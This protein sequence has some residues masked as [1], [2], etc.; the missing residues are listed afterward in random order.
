MTGEREF[1]VV[2]NVD[3][4][5]TARIHD[6]VNLYGCDIGKYS[7]VDAFVY[8]EEGV[9]IGDNCTIR[10]FTFIPEGVT[11]GDGVFVGPGVTFTNDMYPSTDGEWELLETTVENDVAIGAGAVVLPGIMLRAGALVGAGA[12]VTDDVAAESVVAGNPATEIE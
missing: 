3:V 7:K 5:R 1:S 12:V 9:E 6:H 2:K 11:I 10:P 8:I 4:D